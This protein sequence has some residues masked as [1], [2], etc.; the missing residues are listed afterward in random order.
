MGSSFLDAVKQGKNQGWRYGC[1]ILV[2]LVF[3]LGFGQIAI[4]TFFLRLPISTEQAR[5]HFPDFSLP[6][7][8]SI[9][10]P[11]I[12]LLI[13]VLLAVRWVH[14]RP[15]TTLVGSDA[16]L[17][18]KRLFASFG[19]CW[20]LLATG[21]GVR[22]VLNPQEYVWTFQPEQWFLFLPVALLLTPLQTAAEEVLFRGYLLQ[23]LGLL[24]RHPIPLVGLTSAPFAIAHF[25][26]PE[27]QRGAV[28]VSLLYL[29]FSIFLAVI[30]LKDNRLEL[31]LGAHAGNNLFILLIANSSDSALLSPAIL[32][33]KEGS[34]PRLDLA[35][36][37]I[38]AMVFYWVFFGKQE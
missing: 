19:V 35:I 8:V 20:L 38:Q 33:I 29:T 24:T 22:Y 36:L 14:Q 7:Y 30:T 10:L 34:D 25:L 31:A 28:W 12:F 9:H 3:W 37:L 2:I 15:I 18:W 11:F 6:A 13:G 17:H 16:H 5:Q 21:L 26:N 4:T 23:S 27:M 32:M 1:A